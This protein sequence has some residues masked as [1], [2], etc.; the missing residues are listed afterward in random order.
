MVLRYAHEDDVIPIIVEDAVVI[1]PANRGGLWWVYPEGDIGYFA[2]I[3]GWAWL[4]VFAFVLMV[5]WIDNTY[6]REFSPILAFIILA[7]LIF[8]CG[9]GP[10]YGVHGDIPWALLV[11]ALIVF[12][13]G[14]ITLLDSDHISIYMGS[15]Q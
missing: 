10:C 7:I 5:G 15:N 11:G 2:L 1:A 8:S 3:L 14:P 9:M 13:M 6:T 4:W 12:W